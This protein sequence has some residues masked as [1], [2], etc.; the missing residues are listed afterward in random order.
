MKLYVF[1][2]SRKIK[3]YYQQSKGTNALIDQAL[4]VAE[5]LDKI[6]LS[7]GFRAS[8]YEQLLLMQEA[9]KKSQNLEQKLGI[10][11]EFFAFLKNNEYLFSFFRELALENKSI[12]DLQNSDY[13]AS[14]NEHLEILD[15]VFQNYLNLLKREN[16]YDELSLP[17]SYTLNLDFLED[18]E[19]IIYDLEGFLSHFELSLL[20][21]I[22]KHK[23]LILRFKTSKFN[24]AYFKEL[25]FL[26]DVNLKENYHYEFN[27]T[28]N[29]LLK[30]ESL[31]PKSAF[32]KV[33]QFELRILQVAFVL[34]EISSFI[35]AG[36]KA[37]DIVVIT[38]DESFCDFL[39][40]LDQN[41]MLNYASGVSIKESLF[42]QRLRSLY[43]SANL[44]DLHFDDNK[45]YFNEAQN[46]DLHNSLLH[47]FEL[48]FKE[49]KEHFTKECEFSYFETLIKQFLANENS[50]LR[51][52]VEKELFFIKNLLTNQKLNLKQILELF[53]IQISS[54]KQ[55][56]VGGGAVTAMGILESRGLSF[57]GVIVVDFN[58]D[59]IPKRSVNELFLNNE[60]RTKAGLI[61]YEKRENL[62]RFYYEQLFKN[63]KKISIC[64]VE[65]EEKSR[66]RLLEDL[67]FR[68]DLTKEFSQ[69]AYLN[70]LKLNYKAKQ[71]N[72]EPPQ[73]PKLK[74][75]LFA[76]PL[77]YSRLTLFLESKRTYFYKYI[78][79]LKE[80]RELKMDIKEQNDRKRLKN[81][82]IF[83]HRI[84]EL[85]YK[86]YD[87]FD[88]KLFASLLENE[89]QKE[90]LDALDLELLKIKFKEFAKKEQERF[91]QG[92]HIKHLEL[93]IDKSIILEGQR[94]ELT[95]KIDRIDSNERF[96]ELILDYKSGKIPEK[97]YQLAF[98][99]LLYDENAHAAFYDLNDFEL[100]EGK[101]TKSIF[102]LK[103]ELEKLLKEV[104]KEIVF[105]NEKSDF[106]PYKLL[107][108]KDLK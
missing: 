106:C 30:K 29:I 75:N 32:V 84:L 44:D 28:Q 46:F 108:E 99:K 68:L 89:G 37:E 39:R 43:E 103:E 6:C 70:A 104:G 51:L 1:S 61:S 60:V 52:F 73:A 58:E 76:T 97:S 88:E 24:L 91:K 107:Y 45:D 79:H 4:S 7:Q 71:I 105:E 92:Y 64:Y 48:D 86:H 59:L 87:F 77:S 100:K 62:Q 13:Y 38:P 93:N 98:Y 25:P 72:L 101:D 33:Q 5:F 94:I 63:A 27:I 50:E 11:T 56:Y 53:F 49:F 90:G 10:S 78:K 40:L 35:R 15:C 57:D 42:Y 47:Y 20:L 55:S 14:Y 18:Y 22:A 17:L 96:G 9:C 67:E 16:L 26:K 81:L 102:A 19:S 69:K 66:S 3:E 83:I 8:A 85:Y 95:G 41:N 36:L 21:Q 31:K 2:S 12:K 74:H 34:D 82:G 65:N 23:E 54:F 80:P